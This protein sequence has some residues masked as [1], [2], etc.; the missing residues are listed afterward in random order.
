MPGSSLWLVPPVNHPLHATLS[1]LISRD[2]PSRLAQYQT[3][4]FP[5][6]TPHLTLTSDILELPKDPQAWL[7]A[8]NL[9]KAEQ[10]KISIVELDQGDLWTKKLFLRAEKESLKKIWRVCRDVVE[11]PGEKTTEKVQKW[12]EHTWDPHISLI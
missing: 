5:C 2:I 8:L 11:S 4:T 6:F 7:D 9:P 10:V 3:D 1:K 12:V